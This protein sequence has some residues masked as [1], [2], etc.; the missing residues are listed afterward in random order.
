VTVFK[1][2]VCRDAA[3]RAG[4]SATAKL[5]VD[6]PPVFGAPLMVTVLQFHLMIGI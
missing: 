1:K 5:L 6:T 4:L 2:S 3:R